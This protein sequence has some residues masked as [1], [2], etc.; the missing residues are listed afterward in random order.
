MKALEQKLVYVGNGLNL[1]DSDIARQVGLVFQYGKEPAEMLK[2]Y[3]RW[4]SDKVLGRPQSQYGLT[5]QQL[6]MVGIAGVY[7]I[8]PIDY[9][10]IPA[11]YLADLE[12]RTHRQEE[13]LVKLRIRLLRFDALKD[14]IEEM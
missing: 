14:Y 7:R 11:E 10:S 2:R 9:V 12:E 4:V 1:R 5:E 13:E 8:V 3:L 6:Q